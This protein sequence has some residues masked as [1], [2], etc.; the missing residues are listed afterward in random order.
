MP[1][2]VEFEDHMVYVGTFPIGID[3]E[4]FDQVCACLGFCFS[5][6]FKGLEEPAIVERINRLK[7]KFKDVKVLV[8]VDRLDYIKGVPQKL[9]ALEVFL[10]NHPDFQGKVFVPIA[11]SLVYFESGCLDSS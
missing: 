8:G 1:N 6:C 5:S 2:G 10:D 9:H 4:K 3:P 11:L 7:E